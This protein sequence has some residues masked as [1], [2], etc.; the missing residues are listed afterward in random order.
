MFTEFSFLT[1]AR[2]YQES[3]RKKQAGHGSGGDGIYCDAGAAVALLACQNYAATW[4]QPLP[5]PVYLLP[6]PESDRHER[7][8]RK[9]GLP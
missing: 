3:A 4:P 7:K 6:E 8:A 9:Q 1:L 2:G 5:L